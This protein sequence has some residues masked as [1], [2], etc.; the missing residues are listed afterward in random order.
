MK[1]RATDIVREAPDPAPLVAHFEDWFRSIVRR[2]VVRAPL[3]LVARQ[4]WI[5][6]DIAPDEARAH[7]WSFGRGRPFEEEIATYYD[8]GVW[9]R[10]M[11]AVDDS[12]VKVAREMGVAEIDL[13]P[14][15]PGDWSLWYDEIHHTPEGCRRIGEAVAARL[16]ELRAARRMRATRKA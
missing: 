1:A 6:R 14:V 13:R 9:R 8:Y 5:E 12:A 7:C 11:A 3:V 10:L 4:P 15:V 16:V 2:A